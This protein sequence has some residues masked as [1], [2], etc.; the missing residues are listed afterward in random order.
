MVKDALDKIGIIVFNFL[1]FR[2]D[3]RVFPPVFFIVWVYN[4]AAK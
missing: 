4:I 3:G 2:Q 1:L